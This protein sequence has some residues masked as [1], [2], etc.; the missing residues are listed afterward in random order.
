MTVFQNNPSQIWLR[1][2]SKL[3]AWATFVLIFIGGMVTS[4]GSGLSVPDWPLSYGSLFPPM[5]G[6]VF[7][8]HGHRMVASFVGFLILSLAIW[9]SFKEKRR[10]VR[11]L[12]F[13][14]LA[15]VILQGVLGG[16]TV[17]HFLPTSLSVSHAV[18]AQTL[19]VLTVVIAYSQSKERGI[20]LT[21]REET[22][23]I[24]LK[25]SVCV[26]ILVY[27]QLIVGA[28]MRHTGSGLAIPDFPTMGGYWLPPFNDTMLHRINAW[29]FENNLDPVTL[30][31]VIFH[32]CHRLGAILI[33][34][35]SSFLTYF[36]LK[37]HAQ[38]KRIIQTIY[39]IDVMIIA[40]ITLG[41]L[42]VLTQKQP[43][44]TSFHVMV[45]AGVLGVSVLL[46]LRAL[47]VTLQGLS[48]I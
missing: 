2:F 33:L 5:I 31:Q 32:F 10:W 38:Q 12:G 26:V 19:F 34:I 37:Y 3:T 36:G 21:E 27:V 24:F 9:L 29:R 20:R 17:L 23:S 13:C 28:I 40:Q 1:H 14:A 18:L 30:S 41:I 16:L 44:L 42:T 35:T 11:N 25:W 7:Y 4:T 6:G 47:P 22:R 45:G 39:L 43:I 46:T 8:E 15:A 48:K